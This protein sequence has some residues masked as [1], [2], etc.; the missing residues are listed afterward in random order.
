MDNACNIYMKYLKIIFGG[1]KI[2]YIYLLNE[3]KNYD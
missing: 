2:S 3:N 1:K